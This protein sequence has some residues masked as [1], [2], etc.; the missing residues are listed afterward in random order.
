MLQKTTQVNKRSQSRDLKTSQVGNTGRTGK[1]I[2]LVTAGRL[3][4]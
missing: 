3:A 4:T 1:P 2:K